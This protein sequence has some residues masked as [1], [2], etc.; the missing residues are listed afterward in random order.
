V[1]WICLRSEEVKAR[2]EISRLYKYLLFSSISKEVRRLGS[3]FL[4]FTDCSA[5]RHHA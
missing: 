3:R 4:R 1:S 2:A 5:M